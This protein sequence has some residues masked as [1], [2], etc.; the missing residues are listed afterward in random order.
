M[1]ASER[2]VDDNFLRDV[3]EKT[4]TRLLDTTRRNRLLNYKESARDI[5]IVDEMPSQVHEHLVKDGGVF[6]FAQRDQSIHRSD[7]NEERYRDDRLQTQFQ[8]KEL[9]RRLDKLYR[10]HRTIIEESGANNLYVAIGFLEW[11]DA[12]EDAVPMRSPLML[13]SVRLVKERAPGSAA[14]RLK[15]DEQALDS[16]FSLAEKLKQV[17]VPLPQLA[18]EETP[19]SYWRRVDEAIGHKR[20]E[21]WSVVREMAL[22]LFRFNKQVMWHDLNPGRWPKHAP[23]T[24]KAMI[25]RILIGPGEDEAPPGVLTHEY[26]PDEASN[27]EVPDLTLIRDADSSQ[28]SALADALARKDGLVIEGPPGTGKSQTI[29]NLIAAA[30]DQG[31]SVLFVAEKMAALE[32]VYKRLREAKL[33]RFCL[34]LHG[35]TTSKKELLDTVMQRINHRVG[36]PQEREARR[37]ELESARQDLI[38]Y[39]RALSATAGPENIPMYQLPW[40]LE[41]FRQALSEGFQAIGVADPESIRLAPFQRARYLLNNLGR[42]WAAIPEDAREAWSGFLP[43]TYDSSQQAM[44]ASV[45]HA[46]VA[47]VQRMAAWLEAQGA[48]TA[49]VELGRVHLLWALADAAAAMPA[50]PAGADLGLLFA[51]L[52][53]DLVDQLEDMLVRLDAYFTSVSAINQVFDHQSDHAPAY[54]EKLKRHAGDLINTACSPETTVG[55]LSAERDRITRVIEALEALRELAAPVTELTGGF[56]RG[57]DDYQ[58]L[59]N[60]ARMLAE[61]PAELSLHSS[62]AHARASAANY[63]AEARSQATALLERTTALS[64]FRLERAADSATVREAYECVRVR[65]GKWFVVFDGEYRNAKRV[66]KGLLRKP[67]D[68]SRKVEFIDRVGQLLEFCEARAC[69]AADDDLKAA[70]G[71]LFRGVETDWGKLH[72]LIEFSQNLRKRLD[73]DR[74]QRILSDW[75]VHVDRMKSTDHALTR[76]IEVIEGFAADHPFPQMMWRRPIAEIA[77]TLKPWKDKLALAADAL[78][79]PWCSQNVSLSGALR[80]VETYAKACRDEKAIEG[81]VAFNDLLRSYWQRAATRVEPL[82]EL[83]HWLR[84]R[85]AVRGLDISLLRWLMPSPSGF[86][87]ARFNELVAASKEFR[88]QVSVQCTQLKGFGDLSL[89]AWVGGKFATLPDFER[90]LLHCD[91]TLASVP[92]MVRW[93]IVEK[94]VGKL[95]LQALSGAVSAGQLVGDQCGK[96]FEYSVYSRILKDRIAADAKLRAFSHTSY[97]NLRE[98]FA[99]LDRT[100]FDLNAEHVAARL[101]QANVPAGIGYGPVTNYTEKRLL[102]HEAGKRARHIPIR[103]L[104]ARAGNALQALKPCFLMSPLS[105]AQYLA[106]GQIEFDLVVMDEASQMRPEDALGAIARGRKCIIVGDPKQLPPTSFFD[107]A[108]AEEDDLDETIVDDTESILD[109]CQ[110]QLPFRRLRWHYRSQHESLIQFSNEQFYDNDLIVFPSPRRSAREFGVHS[111]FIEAPTY[112][113]GRNRGEAE[114]VVQNILQHF[115]HNP[116]ASLGV[117]AFNKRQAEEIEALLEKARRDDP[118]V[119]ELITNHESSEPLFIKNLENVQ[120]DERDVIFISTTYGP[121]TQGGPVYQ[122]FG[123]INSDLGWRRLNVIATR[124]RQRVEVFTSMRPVDI[125]IGQEVRRGPR[126]LRNYLEYAA[127]GRVSEH[128]IVKGGAP[129]SEFE[130]AV[131]SI[132]RNLGYECDL[133]VGVSGF[134][135]DIGVRHPDRTGEYLMGIEC[136]GA[137]YHS[138]KAVRD[139]DRLRQQI[140]E[141]KGWTIHRIWSTSWFHVRAAEI[142][143][144]KRALAQR[145]DEDRKLWSQLAERA[146]VTEVI[147]QIRAGDLDERVREEDAEISESLEKALSRFWE[148]NIKPRFPDRETSILSEE[149]IARLVAQ[150][151]DNEEAWFRAIPMNRRQAMDPRQKEYLEDILDLIADYR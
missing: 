92:L 58:K 98:R 133:Q 81:H 79:R 107:T 131:A 63:F 151:P 141:R 114:V 45:L 62:P 54:V 105:V 149:M 93:R 15:Y 112:R 117:A 35:L 136:D 69:F 14:Y 28:F 19:E 47:A 143:R 102:V 118:A 148:T 39:S 24:D 82:R 5:A 75:D 36:K 103:Q 9:E 87:H 37:Q 16:N 88:H 33:D 34:Q 51:V 23:L 53:G 144:L 119:D 121:E 125:Q 86:N 12:E 26:S 109:V 76:S 8:E 13:V 43:D 41:L 21:R 113:T 142:D 123:P 67:R 32:V 61:G 134:F 80:C 65:Q 89:K 48:S 122:R 108:I 140:L 111:T 129:D 130:I 83:H 11:R 1:D 60:Q 42:Q 106:P 120:G 138:A 137:T 50:L 91:A 59:A 3:L 78:G 132:L 150:R 2:T 139:R 135:V 52:D 17:N 6:Y 31:L 96:A 128:G 74:A 104:I 7:D 49:K 46:S 100:F 116:E 124:A 110:K 64:Q 57:L 20:I 38:A 30:L 126:S 85:L 101:C 72:G 40:R 22:G 18:D 27:G 66:V 29:T 115:R 99:T 55:D 71:G 10:E 145:L 84:D 44:L 97:E 127:T 146:K 77:A 90:K 73:G 25:R 68:Y 95:G 94:E 147:T 4:R 70:L 56:A